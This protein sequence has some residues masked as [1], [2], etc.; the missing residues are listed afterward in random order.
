MA[1]SVQMPA[2]GEASPTTPLKQRVTPL[3]VD[4]PLLEVTNLGLS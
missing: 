1:V 4:E 2:L 3:V